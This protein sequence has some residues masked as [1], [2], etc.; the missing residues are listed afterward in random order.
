MSEPYRCSVASEALTEP[1][2]GTAST[3]RA[4]L[5]VEVPGP[6]GVDAVSGSRLPDEVKLRL[7]ELEARHRVRPLLIR[8]H[9]GTRRTTTRVYAAFVHSDRP[10]TEST[11]LMDVRELLDLDVDGL[12]EG[13]SPG[14]IPHEEP[15]FLV[16]THGKHDA[17]CAERGRPLCA[18]MS[19][20]APDNTWEVSHIGGDRF[21]ANLLVLPHGLYYGRL[22]P[23]AAGDVVRAHFA[24]ELDLEHLR[25]RCAY[26]FPVQ[27]AEIFLRQHTRIVTA[28]PLVLEEHERHGGETRAVFGYEGK[29]WEV[30]V[31]TGRGE[32]R[33]LTCRASSPTAGLSHTLVSIS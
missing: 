26:P 5:L 2:T 22:T 23:D 8:G 24:G 32:Q 31:A 14:L 28:A 1:L 13:R 11:L 18:A 16:C 19:K 7:S 27:A 21:A 15:L 20:V 17:C 33:Q 30:R 4:L 29:R 9:G 6:W 3:V 25:G 10:W 12:A